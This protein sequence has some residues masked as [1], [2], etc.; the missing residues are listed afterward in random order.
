MLICLLPVCRFAHHFLFNNNTS[1]KVWVVMGR[2]GTAFLYGS[3]IML[4]VRT[5]QIRIIWYSWDGIYFCNVQVKFYI[6]VQQLF[7][8]EI[9]LFWEWRWNDVI[10]SLNIAILTCKFIWNIFLLLN[11]RFRNLILVRHPPCIQFKLNI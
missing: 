8:I 4:F 5:S 6:H 9:R 2:W 11:I 7:D 1:K 3:H 10:I